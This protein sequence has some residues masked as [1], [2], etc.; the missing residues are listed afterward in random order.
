MNTPHPAHPS[1]R[2]LGPVE[3]LFAA[4][5]DTGAMQF[6]IAVELEGEVHGN[7]WDQ[8]MHAIA[9][10]HPTFGALLAYD[11]DG[12]RSFIPGAPPISFV[13]EHCDRPGWHDALSASVNT[14]LPPGAAPMR[15]RLLAD[16]ARQLLIATFVHA[17]ADGMSALRVVEDILTLVAGATLPVRATPS[18]DEALGM[19]VGR[20]WHEDRP[21]AGEHTVAPIHLD[22]LELDEAETR[23][24]T[25]AARQHDTTLNSA[26]VVAFG[27]V[28]SVTRAGQGVR[29]MSPV[30]VR[31]QTG[32]TDASAVHIS[33]AVSNVGAPATDFWESAHGV[34][35]TIKAARHPAAVRGFVERL[36]SGMREDPTNA[37]TSLR[38]GRASVFDAILSHLGDVRF[39]G[40][41][42]SAPRVVNVW[43]PVIRPLPGLS[44]IGANRFAS[45]LRLVST[46]FDPAPLLR[47][48]L[49]HLKARL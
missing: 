15:A 40:L 16:G 21:A 14:V 23:R 30:N 12:R 11:K 10:L 5:N 37:A 41:V 4:Y 19:D 47:P 49:E 22:A 48:V 18:L 42:P 1:P 7:R 9:D 38:I 20:F 32:G 17:A 46:S 43:G 45:G 34:H 26:L 36:A 44:I 29:I 33:V 3:T 39:D 31:Q 28:L 2:P 13:I 24:F 6:S 27:E 8:A 35:D 25:E